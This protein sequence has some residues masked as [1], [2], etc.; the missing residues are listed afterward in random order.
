MNV[1]CLLTYSYMVHKETNDELI[2]SLCSPP[3]FFLEE[4]AK[5][6]LSTDFNSINLL[7]SISRKV[8]HG[9][10]IEFRISFQ[11]KAPFLLIIRLFPSL[12]RRTSSSLTTLVSKRM[13]RVWFEI[14][15]LHELWFSGKRN[16]PHWNPWVLEYTYIYI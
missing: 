1:L 6:L 11:S 3:I 10:S 12:L 4:M 2:A 9:N 15:P 16:F 14:K 13:K 5:S 7:H 8:F